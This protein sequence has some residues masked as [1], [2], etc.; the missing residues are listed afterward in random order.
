MNCDSSSACR[1]SRCS[2]W[3][4][5]VAASLLVPGTCL[6]AQPSANDFIA[7]RIVN[8]DAEGGRITLRHDHIPHLHLPAGTTT[9]RYVEA[10]WIIGRAPG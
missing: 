8:I 3:A 2:R 5:L 9:F 10:R 6:F 7:G 1:P 4:L